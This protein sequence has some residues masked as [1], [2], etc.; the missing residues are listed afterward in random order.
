M[1][2]WLS[3][4]VLSL[5]LCFL[6]GA[7]WGH[8]LQEK[9]DSSLP[10]KGQVHIL[11]KEGFFT[12][13]FLEAF[14]NKTRIQLKVETY[15]NPLDFI[16]KL[17]RLKSIEIVYFSSSLFTY[18]QSENLLDPLDSTKIENSKYISTD[19]RYAAW[20]P[21]E[22]FSLPFT[23]NALF[24]V[25]NPEATTPKLDSFKEL[26][27]QFPSEVSLK[28]SLEGVIWLNQHLDFTNHEEPTIYKKLSWFKSPD[29]EKFK[30]GK[31]KY[32]QLS[33]SEVQSLKKDLGQF[34]V[35]YPKEYSPFF[36]HY[37]GL[38]Q[39]TYAQPNV[40]L[41][42]EA[43]NGLYEPAIYAKLIA[44]SSAFGVMESSAPGGADLKS[45][46]AQFFRKLP[47]SKLRPLIN[48]E[49]E[50]DQLNTLIDKTNE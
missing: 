46:S 22:S 17:K 40:E 16:E 27:Q 47:L 29:I 15:K 12:K 26:V 34:E 21:E 41:V 4:S 37:V 35:W 18:L 43:L 25:Y 2:R 49:L 20:D 36:I 7:W 48:S 39:G 14:S 8:R 11:S 31:I 6:V 45:Q 23:W 5:V 24:L 1:K 33:W 3:V 30:S 42:Y 38:R 19:L 13:D 9:K 10:L 44:N 28:S 50:Y 32:L